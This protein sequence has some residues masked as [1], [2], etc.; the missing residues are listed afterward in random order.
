M[1]LLM[2]PAG[3]DSTCD[4]GDLSSI[5]WKRKWQATLVFLPGKSH[6]KR[7]LAGYSPWDCKSQSLLRNKTTR[8]ENIFDI[9]RIFLISE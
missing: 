9:D 2:V 4:V 1:K 6:G 3:K 8:K 5:P 7:S